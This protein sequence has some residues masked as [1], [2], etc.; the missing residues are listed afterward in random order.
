VGKYYYIHLIN[1]IKDTTYVTAFQDT[2]GR[3]QLSE[4][5][6]HFHWVSRY[7][8]PGIDTVFNPLWP[9]ALTP[10]VDSTRPYIESIKFYR[11][12]TNNQLVGVLDGK[13]DILSVAG[14]TRTDSTG[15]IPAIAGNVSVYKIGYEV[16]DTLGNLVKPYWEKIKFD[17]IPDPSNISQLNLT[18]GSGS[19]GSHFRSWVSNDPFNDT[20]AQRNW[21]WNTKQQTGQPDSV[22][23]DSIENAKFKDCYYW[24]KVM[25]YDIRNN[26][27]TE[28]VDFC[29]NFNI[30][31]LEV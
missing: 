4:A 25:A 19:T 3:I 23:A 17:T 15:H 1:R 28:N 30:M 5:H 26:A 16:R 11:Q 31:R 24:V 10:Y 13:V 21:Y 29:R 8:P 18:Y 22:D 27:D 2:I 6:L 14:D 9:T 12:G 7:P 20:V